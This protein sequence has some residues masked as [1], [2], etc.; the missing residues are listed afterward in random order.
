MKRFV[1][2]V[3]CFTM[4]QLSVKLVLMKDDLVYD[5]LINQLSYERI[6]EIL[7]VS[8]K[9]EWI[10]YVFLPVI[11]LLKVLFVVICFSIGTLILGVHSTF[12]RLFEIGVSSE[13]IFIIPTVIKLVWFS[14]IETNYTLQHLQLFSPLSMI[15]LFNPTELDAWLVYPIQL[16]NVFELLYWIALAWQLQEVLEKPFAESLGF[17]AKTYGVGL[18]VWVVV[19]MFLT[20]SIS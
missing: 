5:S 17:V 20:V 4:L 10:S 8:K 18:A 15:S 6:S 3:T 2:L 1:A 11:L 14:L 12:K 13:F 9:W 7:E 19:V 16:L